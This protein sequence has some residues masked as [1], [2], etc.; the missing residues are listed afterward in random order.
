[1]R[2]LGI[3][4]DLRIFNADTVDVRLLKQVSHVFTG[5]REGDPVGE[6]VHS[7]AAHFQYIG[8]TLATGVT[9]PD[10]RVGLYQSM[11]WQAR[12]GHL[13]GNLRQGRHR[14]RFS[15]PNERTQ[16][17]TGAVVDGVAILALATLV[18]LGDF[19]AAMP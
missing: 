9:N 4:R 12:S 7:S 19:A 11:V 13:F 2:Q 15:G 1:M 14:Q 16:Y 8:Q 6:S 18:A 10:F 5:F 17:L 3:R